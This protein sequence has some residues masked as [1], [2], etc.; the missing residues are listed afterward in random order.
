MLGG[1]FGFLDQMVLGHS[2]NEVGA[3]ALVGMG[4]VFAGSIR[5][6]ITSVLIIFEMTGS[7][8]LILPL[9]I[10]NMTA[11]V[12][13]RQWKP[14]PI[15]EA[16]LEQDGVHLPHH[17]G[18]VSH[19]LEQLRVGEAMTPKPV[20]L[21][22]TSTV[23]EALQRIGNYDFST[24]PVIAEGDSFTGMVSEAR[25]RRTM[26]EGKGHIHV[27]QLAGQ[28]DCVFPDQPLVRAVVHMNQSNVRQ[29]A[30][31]ERGDAKVLI[32]LLT[33]SDIVSAQARAALTAGEADK[34][35]APG[36]R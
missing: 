13:A 30:V 3:F 24:Y 17:R 2:G 25:L 11:Y 23:A 18:A 6:P 5:A 20:A 35:I 8:R 22:A 9:M 32:G 19:A 29:L 21:P 15:Y 1:T 33:M 27:R 4:T 31:L 16:L 12:L 34:T 14:V 26:A 28:G 7:Y 36:F 10:A